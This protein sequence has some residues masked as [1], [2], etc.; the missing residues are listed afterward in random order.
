MNTPNHATDEQI[1]RL[2]DLLQLSQMR[3][4]LQA[5]REAHRNGLYEWLRHNENRK[6][7]R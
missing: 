5:L 7:R 2:W 3:G 4:Q 1:N 6:I